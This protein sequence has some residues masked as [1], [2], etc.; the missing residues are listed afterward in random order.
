M[1]WLALLL[2]FALAGCAAPAA[3]AP[4]PSGDGRTARAGDDLEDVVYVPNLN[5][6]AGQPIH[7]QLDDFIGDVAVA[8]AV[9]SGGPCSAGIAGTRTNDRG[10]GSLRHYR[11]GWSASFTY[12]P[13]AE[14]AGQGN[15]LP[16]APMPHSAHATVDEGGWTGLWLSNLAP[17]PLAPALE[18]DLACEKASAVRLEGARRAVL[19]GGQDFSSD[20]AV[21]VPVALE[22]V[23]NGKLSL[24][25]E[26]PASLLYSCGSVA[27]TCTLEA[28]GP[29]GATSLAPDY[30]IQDLVPGSYE[31][32]LD[33]VNS[34]FPLI[35]AIAEFRPVTTQDEFLGLPGFG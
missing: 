28:E 17:S 16:G 23:A 25:F 21:T 8:V 9:V 19:T 14:V 12:E 34:A 11:E 30:R 1:R 4:E 27:G 18:F 20:A 33:A 15:A 31:F 24:S 5:V 3:E 32:T 2:G 13:S 6:S 22:V 26:R 7:W 35:F 29:Q 10:V